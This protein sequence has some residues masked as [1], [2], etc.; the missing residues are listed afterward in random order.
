[1]NTT[2]SADNLKKLQVKIGGMQCSFCI[3][4]LRKAFLGL[5]GVQEASISLAHEEA[6]VWYDPARATPQQIKDTLVAMG[7]TWRDPEKVR[8]FEEE[9]AELG[10]AR[11]KFLVGAGAAGIVVIFMVL[12]WL[13]VMQPWF[14]WPMLALALATMFGPAWHIK[15]MAWSSLKRGILNQHVLL[16][17]AAFAGLTGG[18]IGFFVKEFPIPD[19]FGVATFVTAYHLLSGY[20]S[21]LART[22]SSQAIKRLMALQPATARVIRDGREEDVP[23]GQVKQ[24][25]LVRVRPG[26]SIPV[27]GIIED[28]YSSIDQRLVTGEPMPVEKVK[29][30]EVIGGSVNQTGALVIRVTRVGDESFLQKVAQSIQEARA[31]KPGILIL[32]D[33]VLKYFVPGVLIAAGI[34]FL[35]WTLGAWIITGS[36]DFNRAVFAA[37]AALVMGYPCAL[38]MASPLAMIRGGGIAAEKGILMRSGEAFQVFKDVRRIVLDKTG[39]ITQGEPSV[40]DIGLMDGIDRSEFLGLVASTETLS[41]HAL[42][43]AIVDYVTARGGVPGKATDFQTYP[44]KGVSASV[45]SKRVVVGTGRFLAEQGIDVSAL[46]KDRARLEEEGKTVVLAAID[47]RPAGVIAISDTIKEDTREAVESMRKAGLEP[48][49]ITGDNWRTARAVAGLVG[50]EKVLAE[51]LPGDKA[52]EVRKLQRQGYRVAMVGD[53]INDAPALMQADV[54]IAVGTGTDIAIESADVILIGQN[55]AGVMEAYRI[56]TN[57]YTKTVQNVSLAFTFNGIG[58]PAAVTGLV[59]PVWAMI[60]MAASVTTVLLNS[61]GGR[62]IHLPHFQKAREEHVLTLEVPSIHCEGC[63]ETIENA[64]RKLSRVQ[65]VKVNLAEK[66]VEV[67]FRDGGT[68]EQDIQN[69]IIRVGHT[70][71]GHGH[72]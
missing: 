12:M 16:E 6:L 25:D 15:R 68:V 69:A 27:D 44:G 4:T 56:G 9:E 70:I 53:G 46:D 59:H 1:M 43:R 52:E 8:S 30:D 26:E 11:R 57:S 58:V 54:G 20:I 17:F 23:T 24:G 65:N 34:A 36:P 55:L 5:D 50:I 48:V 62:I 42:A 10:V 3:E 37:L 22:R 13:G 32:V 19:F 21:L 31:L 47:G 45:D 7:Y 2:M 61:F 60:A 28:G 35:I 72:S 29:G 18:F 67:T 40:S 39:T 71:A 41:E 49:M 66:L 38:G 64:L 14:R 63:A 51:V 33:R